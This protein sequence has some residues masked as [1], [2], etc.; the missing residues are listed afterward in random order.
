MDHH[1]FRLQRSCTLTILQCPWFIAMILKQRKVRRKLFWGHLDLR[2]IL[3]TT[4]MCTWVIAG[5]EK[6][7]FTVCR[8]CGQ[9]FCKGHI[10][11]VL[12]IFGTH[13]RSSLNTPLSS[14][15]KAV[16]TMFTHLWTP[17]FLVSKVI[18]WYAFCALS[19]VGQKCNQICLQF[20]SKVC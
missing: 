8:M 19:K 14:R 18:I 10:C 9:R 12:M 17:L 16:N 13:Q 5:H 6:S 1:D 7:F 15:S 2:F 4:P 11:T 20:K 3:T